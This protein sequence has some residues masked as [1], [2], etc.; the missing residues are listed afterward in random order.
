MDSDDVDDV[1]G[2]VEHS[3][4]DTVG[5][6]EAGGTDLAVDEPL[7]HAVVQDHLDKGL[8]AAFR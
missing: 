4:L 5:E 1:P 3:D 7:L 8:N 2:V 6:A